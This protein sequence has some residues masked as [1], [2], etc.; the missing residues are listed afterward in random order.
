MR[1]ACIE[2]GSLSGVTTNPIY[3]AE[4]RTLP[5]NSFSYGTYLLFTPKWHFVLIR[6]HTY[7]YMYTTPKWRTLPFG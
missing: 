4:A 1:R 3:G 2:L 7:L 6:I 5:R